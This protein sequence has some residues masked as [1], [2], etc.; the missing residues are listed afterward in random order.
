LVRR[1]RSSLFAERGTTRTTEKT[2]PI[3]RFRND[4]D[5]EDTERTAP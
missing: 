1:R 5:G 3:Q 2:S 4:G